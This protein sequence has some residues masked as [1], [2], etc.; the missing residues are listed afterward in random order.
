MTKDCSDGVEQ[1]ISPGMHTKNYKLHEDT[2][3]L[4]YIIHLNEILFN[5]LSI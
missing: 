5:I 2:I 4:L 3:G 1:V